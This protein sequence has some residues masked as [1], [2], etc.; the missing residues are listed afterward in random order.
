LEAGMVRT[1]IYLTDEE[2]K[3]IRAL[4]RLTS[5]SQSELIRQAIDAMVSVSQPRARAEQLRRFAGMWRGRKDLPDFR[6]L[7]K[8]W[9]RAPWTSHS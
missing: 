7:R 5:K 3:G 8:E 6:A 4:S 1:Q 9:D 2:Q